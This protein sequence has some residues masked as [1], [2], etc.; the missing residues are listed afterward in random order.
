MDPNWK[1]M[2]S[3]M[4]FYAK[5]ESNAETKSNVLTDLGNESPQQ[6]VHQKFPVTKFAGSSKSF[7][8]VDSSETCPSFGFFLRLF[9]FTLVKDTHLQDVIKYIPKVATYK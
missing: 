6:P 3:L 2:K 8:A 9:E 7:C 5:S 4:D 1:G